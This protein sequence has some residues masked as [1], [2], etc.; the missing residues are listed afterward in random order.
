MK[1]LIVELVDQRQP[2]LGEGLGR[3]PRL[4]LRQ[5]SRFDA[6]RAQVGIARLQGALARRGAWR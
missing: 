4:G 3:Y 1:E 6:Y 2:Q 5:Q